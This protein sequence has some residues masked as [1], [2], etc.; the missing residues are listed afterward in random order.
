M[1]LLRANLLASGYEVETAKQGKRALEMIETSDYDLLI[2]D[3]MLSDSING[4]EVCKK[5]REFSNIPII[6]LTS[7][8]TEHDRINGFNAGADDYLTKP[9]S[10]KELLCR[11]SAV[12]KRAYT[13]E[14]YT[15][16]HSC[17]LGDLEINFAQRRVFLKEQEVYLTATE[18]HV[19]YYL[20]QNADK[21][22][23]H[24]DLLAK[25]WGP[26]Y[27][28]ELQYLRTYISNLRKK[29]GDDPSNPK[30]ILSKHGVGYCLAVNHK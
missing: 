5:I 13:T 28:D 19:L 17:I 20:A 21:V 23:L 9:F 15:K 16:P 30:Y 10:V 4:F 6:M 29:I 3:I 27:R 2:L 7:R 26:E 25:V 8:S 1:R 18:Y 11:I 24:E 12:L 22:I 14:E